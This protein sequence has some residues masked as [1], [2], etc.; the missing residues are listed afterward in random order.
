MQF[1]QPS[2]RISPPKTP[3]LPSASA[4]ITTKSPFFKKKEIRWTVKWS[5]GDLAQTFWQKFKKPKKWNFFRNNLFLKLILWACW[6]LFDK[7]ATILRKKEMKCVRS[8]PEKKQKNYIF[9]K[10]NCN[11]C[12]CFSG[13]VECSLDK[14]FPLSTLFCQI[15]QNQPMDIEKI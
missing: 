13:H 11:S 7:P 1:S 8:K 3:K 2:E 5:F 10:N 9:F 15:F 12:K 4:T 6:C 14:H